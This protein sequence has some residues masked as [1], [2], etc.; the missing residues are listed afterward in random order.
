V[1]PQRVPRSAHR[2][3]AFVTATKRRRALWALPVQQPSGVL[4][5]GPGL[6]SHRCIRTARTARMLA[7]HSTNHFSSRHQPPSRSDTQ[8]PR[9]LP[10]PGIAPQRPHQFANLTPSK[11]RHDFAYPAPAAPAP[12]CIFDASH[13]TLP[14]YASEPPRHVAFVNSSHTACRATS[15]TGQA[16]GSLS[17]LQQQTPHQ[18]RHTQ[19][20]VGGR[21]SLSLS[22]VQSHVRTRPTG[23][24]Q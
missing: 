16:A 15:L 8:R 9:L 10:A 3:A 18:K 19:E 24:P 6:V 17:P 1:S 20:K 22:L 11:P 12:F 21:S 2:S 7:R 13:G 23:N 5:D 14:A 4:I